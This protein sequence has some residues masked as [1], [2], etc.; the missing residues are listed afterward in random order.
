MRD[1]IETRQGDTIQGRNGRR[2][3]MDL[4]APLIFAL[5]SVVVFVIGYGIG[6]FEGGR[7]RIRETFENVDRRPSQ[8][9]DDCKA[10][11]MSVL[12]PTPPGTASP[13]PF[14]WECWKHPPGG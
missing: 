8:G 12:V 11:E 2:D 7:D 6:Y 10:G 5:G 13:R 14:A 3:P 4:L 1:E 9:P